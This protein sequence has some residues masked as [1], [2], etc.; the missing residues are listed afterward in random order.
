MLRRGPHE[1]TPSQNKQ[2]QFNG[3]VERWDH[4]ALTRS[5]RAH[6]PIFSLLCFSAVTKTLVKL[7]DNNDPTI[8]WS[9]TL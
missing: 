9:I 8:S 7:R 6:V 4:E 3:K 1:G 5:S 2:R